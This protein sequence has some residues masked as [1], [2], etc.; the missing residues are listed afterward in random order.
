MLSFLTIIF[1]GV[2]TDAAL[3]AASAQVKEWARNKGDNLGTPL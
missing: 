3:Y 2:A 1:A